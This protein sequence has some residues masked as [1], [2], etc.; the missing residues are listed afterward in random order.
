MGRATRLEGH[1][2]GKPQTQSC[3]MHQYFRHWHAIASDVWSGLTLVLFVGMILGLALTVKATG[4]RPQNVTFTSAQPG[5]V[6]TSE[7]L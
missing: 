5:T 2:S 1:V 4:E 6:L 3:A 7:R